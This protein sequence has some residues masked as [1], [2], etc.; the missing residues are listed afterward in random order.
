MI[1]SEMKIS[2]S[3]FWNSISTEDLLVKTDYC[4][5]CYEQSS[6]QDSLVVL[7]L[8]TTRSH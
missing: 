1:L 2:L 4:L 5:N 3:S 7:A 6:D 8:T